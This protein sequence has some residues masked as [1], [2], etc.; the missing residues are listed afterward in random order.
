MMSEVELLDEGGYYHWNH[1]MLQ[2]AEQLTMAWQ[3]IL[4][5][6]IRN[7]HSDS[8]V[9]LKEQICLRERQAR[10]VENTAQ[11]K[12][13]AGYTGENVSRNSGGSGR[14]SL[15]NG[16]CFYGCHVVLC[17]LADSF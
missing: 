4:A 7:G 3:G 13:A 10:P 8:M 17:L 14:G 2:M 16:L 9:T 6:I 1:K 11:L 5:S 12:P 15:P